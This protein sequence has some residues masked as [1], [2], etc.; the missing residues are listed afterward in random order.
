MNRPTYTVII[1]KS[2]KRKAYHTEKYLLIK[3]LKFIG[4]LVSAAAVMLLF[5][6]MALAENSSIMPF[7]VV[8]FAGFGL[9]VLI[10]LIYSY[11]SYK[12]PWEKRGENKKNLGG[13]QNEN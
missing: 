9:M 10:S 3:R 1:H 5:C 7:Q 8:F 11:V 2:G 12:E 4:A 6:G 13:K